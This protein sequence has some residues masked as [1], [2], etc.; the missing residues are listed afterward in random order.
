LTN[1]TYV[2]LFIADI[3]FNFRTGIFVGRGGADSNDEGGGGGELVEYDRWEVAKAYLFS[4]FLL[5][6]VSGIPFALIDRIMGSGGSGGALKAMKS[7][8]LLRFLK[9]GRL[10]KLEKILSNLDRDTLDKL[11][12]FIQAG[13]TRSAIVMSKLLIGLA[14]ACH[15]LACGFVLVGRYGYT[16]YGCCGET[17]LDADNLGPFKA[18]DTSGID[19]GK[20]V[21]TIY[22]AAFYF[23]LTTMTSVGYGDIITHNNAERIF[24]VCLQFIGAIIFA[25]VIAQITAVVSTMDTNAR[26]TA[27]QL[28]AVT[29]FV[30]MR[31]FPEALGRRIRRHFR[32]FYS[33]KSAIDEAKIFSELSTTLRREVSAYLVSE[34][35]GEESFFSTMPP[36]LWPRI[37]PLLCPT[38]FEQTELVAMQGE[39]CS[40]LYVVLSGQVTGEIVVTGEFMPRVRRITAGN[41][42]NVLAALGCWTKCVET[43]VCDTEVEA[44]AVVC[45]DFRALFTAENDVLEFEK[46]QRYECRN[47]KM[48]TS[49]LDAPYGQP[50]YYI[51]FATLEFTL[52]QAKGLLNVDR[53]AKARQRSKGTSETEGASWLV[54]DLVDKV[55]GK[56][57]QNGTMWRH[58]TAR[59]PLKPAA[60]APDAAHGGVDM[61]DEPYWGET[62]LWGDLNQPFDKVALRVRLYFTDNAS[63]RLLGKVLIPLDA[64]HELSQKQPSRHGS[65]TMLSGAGRDR[66]LAILEEGT[67]LSHEPSGGGPRSSSLLPLQ[68]GEVEAWYKLRSPE[69]GTLSTTTSALSPDDAAASQHA[70]KTARSSSIEMAARMPSEEKA[71]SGSDAGKGAGASAVG[72]EGGNNSALALEA[73]ESSNGWG[74]VQIR[75]RAVPAEYTPKERRSSLKRE[76]SRISRSSNDLEHKLQLHKRDPSPDGDKTKISP[77]SKSSSS[78]PKASG[79]KI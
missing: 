76:V 9:L 11:E 67:A 55:S 63:E 26:K 7:L 1:W 37:L 64:A 15:L 27:E 70:V 73:G 35:M 5:D 13:G 51:C 39:E 74:S 24:T 47:F 46:M 72:D 21:M 23:S 58:Q 20:L 49:C 42:I 10:F 19:G 59:A 44:Y 6:I 8:K 48:D 68:A 40:E 31:Q 38:R 57:F 52:V 33:L 16:T 36:N 71:T 17:W 69:A 75:M 65:S 61:A 32:H 28:D 78:S 62:V 60:G 25:M 77:K 79:K 30:E 41:S 54:A 29:S 2:Q 12:D 34:L 18:R 53:L 66:K 14:Y 50:Q 22:I 56:P 45:S 3:V 4:W 43:A